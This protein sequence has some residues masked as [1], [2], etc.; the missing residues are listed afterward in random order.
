MLEILKNLGWR[1]FSKLFPYSRKLAS[2]TAFKAQ[3]GGSTLECM[4]F[5]VGADA[6][7]RS[8]EE[9]L[10][11]SLARSQVISKFH[12]K[13]APE[14]EKTLQPLWT[15]LAETRAIDVKKQF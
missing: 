8:I 15:V 9:R 1:I 12:L 10:Q 11:Q 3:K 2:W 5:I 7:F 4:G 13:R 6:T 14:T